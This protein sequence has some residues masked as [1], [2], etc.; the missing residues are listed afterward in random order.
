MEKKKK[1]YDKKTGEIV[2]VDSI[3]DFLEQQES[4]EAPQE[5]VVVE[6]EE[7]PEGV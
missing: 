2:L 5:E 6:E 3:K 4:E 7:S 1:V